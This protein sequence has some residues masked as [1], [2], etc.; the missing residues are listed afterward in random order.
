MA[1]AVQD[2]REG[3]SV[4]INIHLIVTV[5]LTATVQYLR[6]RYLYLVSE[7]FVP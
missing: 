5:F 2:R 4:I 6:Y 1:I 3:C 7:V